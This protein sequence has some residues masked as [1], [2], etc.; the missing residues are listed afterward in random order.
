MAPDVDPDFGGATPSEEDRRVTLAELYADNSVRRRVEAYARR[1]LK[2]KDPFRCEAIQTDDLVSTVWRRLL[3]TDDV[4]SFATRDD[5]V[6]Y[7]LTAVRNALSDYVKKRN[8]DK[9]GGGQWTIAQVAVE[10]VPGA[11][12]DRPD[13][14]AESL[15]LFRILCER[16]DCWRTDET[17]ELL[18]EIAHRRY[19]LGISVTEIASGLNAE[20]NLGLTPYSIRKHLK[21]SSAI[22]R[23]ELKG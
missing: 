5:F 13:R 7:L 11:D 21:Y 1:E 14:M 3:G 2:K 10:Q 8:A 19:V 9:R 6:R 17:T 18:A 15:E 23:R 20:R 22:L 4:P 12:H 16:I